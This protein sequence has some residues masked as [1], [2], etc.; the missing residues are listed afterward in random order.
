MSALQNKILKHKKWIVLGLIAAA[1]VAGGFA[2]LGGK[3]AA[4]QTQQVINVER[5][6]VISIV[7]ATGTIQPVNMVDISSK[8]TAQIKQVNV[9]ENDPVKAGQVLVI[10][11]D[12]GLQAQVI[13]AQERMN[14]AAANFERNQRLNAIGAVS[15]Q[16]L[17]N[18]RMDYKIA[19]ASYDEVL[20][21][22]NETVITSPI[23]GIVIGKP[24]PAGQM[25]AQGVSNPTV[26]LTVAD[27]S[28]MQIEAQVDQ[29]DIGKVA[30]GQK[31]LFTV[32]AY[33]DRKF[34]GLIANVSQKATTQQ[35]VVYYTI[36][37]EVADAKN[38]LKPSMTARVSIIAGESKNALTLPLAAIKTDKNG[39]YVAVMRENG[40]TENVQITTG[41]IADD[42]IEI[43]SGLNEGDKVV[44]LQAKPQG[45]SN[46][47]TTGNQS[48]GQRNGN[49]SPVGGMM[50]R[51]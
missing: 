14:N 23:D 34:G 21:K 24:L 48:G 4:G 19:K 10:L 42:K 31:V 51:M 38:A 45:Q 35:N 39:K 8:I 33:P 12:T 44:I 25:V 20:S 9:K 7:S 50:R 41:I 5:G 2:Q 37:I 40:Q 49:P 27:V 28:K 6:N 18:S 15:A 16:Q 26:I 43:L 32:D 29:T 1:G 47:Q 17:D 30:V 11:E 36:T 13:Q 46:G 3:K 22:R